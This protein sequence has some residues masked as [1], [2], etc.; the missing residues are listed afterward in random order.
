M[1]WKLPQPTC[2]CWQIR[3]IIRPHLKLNVDFFMNQSEPQMQFL[4][5]M[6]MYLLFGIQT[7]VKPITGSWTVLTTLNCYIIQVS[8]LLQAAWRC[9]IG[10]PRKQLFWSTSNVTRQYD[11]K[12]I[13]VSISKKYQ[14][15]KFEIVLIF[16]TTRSINFLYGL[17]N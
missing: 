17:V 3:V 9:K 12:Y 1:R 6:N 11:H 2:E 13:Y 7:S 4:T 16:S 10:H 8:C 5:P 14:I 15:R